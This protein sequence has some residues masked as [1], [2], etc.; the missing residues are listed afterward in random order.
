MVVDVDLHD[1]ELIIGELKVFLQER[2]KLLARTA[3]ALKKINREC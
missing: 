1:I 3:P 2:A